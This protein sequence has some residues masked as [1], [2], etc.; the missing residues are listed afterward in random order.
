[1]WII[2]IYKND[3]CKMYNSYSTQQILCKS[4]DLKENSYRCLNFSEQ[5]I[6]SLTHFF[7]VLCLFGSDF[8]FSFSR[9]RHKTNKKKKNIEFLYLYLLYTDSSSFSYLCV[10][11]FR[12][13]NIASDIAKSNFEKRICGIFLFKSKPRSE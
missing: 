4:Y 5:K 12:G 1:M 3:A 7:F 10:E 6:K 13:N 2:N 8:F 9:N 11:M